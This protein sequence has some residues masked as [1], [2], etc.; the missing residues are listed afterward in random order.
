MKLVPFQEYLGVEKWINPD[1]VIYVVPDFV[2]DEQHGRINLTKIVYS[3]TKSD[4]TYSMYNN[5]QTQEPINL[6]VLRLMNWHK[7]KKRRNGHGRK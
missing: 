4:K 7:K 3:S 2:R 5:I 1:Y 6:V